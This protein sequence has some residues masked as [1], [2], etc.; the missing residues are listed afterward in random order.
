MDHRGGRGIDRP[1]Q[2]L[3]IDGVQRVRDVR[4]SAAIGAVPDTTVVAD[5]DVIGVIRIH[6]DRVEVRMQVPAEVEPRLAAVGRTID[7]ARL[8]AQV[9][10]VRAAGVDDIRI[11]RICLDDVV[12][13]ALRSAGRAV[14]LDAV[15]TSRALARELGPAR[16]SVDGLP[17]LGLVIRAVGVVPVEARVE[18]G[19]AALRMRD[20]D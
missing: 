8:R 15:L 19:R 5:Q 4:T 7:A 12:I 3:P 18:H 11:V 2:V 16:A 20:R 1:V 6:R 14:V 17:H 9:V 13:R 10:A